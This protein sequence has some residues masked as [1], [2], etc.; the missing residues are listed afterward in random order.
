MNEEIK[1][2]RSPSCPQIPLSKAV[3]LVRQLHLKAGRASISRETAAGALGF[4]S[5]HGQ[6]LSTL[7][8]LG[9][10]GLIDAERGGA[11][12]V[13][14]LSMRLIHPLSAKQENDAREEAVLKPKVFLELFQNGYNDCDEAVL[15]NHLIQSDF[16]PEGARKAA[17]VFK[18]NSEF[19]KL[20]SGS[21][22]QES[23]VP[24]I[25][26]APHVVTEPKTTEKKEVLNPSD[27]NIDL[28]TVKGAREPLR[29]ALDEENDAEVHFSGPDLGVD[30]IDALMDYLAVM[31]KRFERNAKKQTPTGGMTP[32]EFDT[33]IDMMG[34]HGLPPHKE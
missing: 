11:L 8:V 3:E 18:V 30:Q 28:S 1:R 34:Q 6:A 23:N 14:E 19:A 27:I 10:Y 20:G 25:P 7:A 24:E 5:M 12:R 16:T 22:V 32:K 4:Q 26:T 17:S 9:Q 2:G 21:M 29:F 13:S 31:K 15:T 33:A